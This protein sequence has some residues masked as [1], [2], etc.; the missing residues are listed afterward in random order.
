MDSVPRTVSRRGLLVAAA[1]GSAIAFAAPADALATPDSAAPLVLR[2]RIGTAVARLPNGLVASS[3]YTADFHDRLSQWLRFWWA[4]A[5][6]AW[7]APMEIVG[8]VTATGRAYLLSAIRV[9]AAGRLIDGFSASDKN[10]SY[11]GTL[12]SLYQFFP[13]LRPEAGRIRI[14]DGVPEFTGSAQQLAFVSEARRQVWPGGSAAEVTTRAGWHEFA[15][16]TLRL[17]LGAGSF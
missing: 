12:A 3:A 5:P 6:G 17:G 13:V 10:S 1:A 15:R 9:T 4:N 8:E 11:W 14:A 2:E 7:R 16:T